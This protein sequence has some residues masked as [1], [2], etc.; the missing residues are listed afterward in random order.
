MALAYGEMIP[1]LELVDTDSKPVMLTI[2]RVRV[3]NMSK[4]GTEEKLVIEFA[5]QFKPAKDFAKDAATRREYIVN[6]TSWKTL[7]LKLGRDHDKWV[8]QPIVMAPTNNTFGGKTYEKM[9]VAALDR[10]DKVVAATSRARSA[11]R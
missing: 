1:K 7:V 5:E 9:H 10:W 2:A 4:T 8:G 3:Q 6:S 11:K